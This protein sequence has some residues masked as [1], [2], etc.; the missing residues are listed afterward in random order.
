MDWIQIIAL[1]LIFIAFMLPSLRGSAKTAEAKKAP[2]DDKR[3][4]KQT[5]H[6]EKWRQKLEAQDE[7]DVRESEKVLSR[8]PVPKSPNLL[9]LQEKKPFSSK[10]SF[11]SSLEKR[12]L[13]SAIEER[14]LSSAISAKGGENLVSLP[15]S[16]EKI[17][18]KRNKISAAGKILKRT[19][20]RN[21]IISH[22]ILKRK[23]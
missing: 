19:S 18:K 21:L 20:K 4:Q 5:L 17:S 10:F 7:K 11:S 9:S 2:P 14:R 3:H 22:E 23:F 16:L 8:P 12:K 15:I 13:T 6:Q 1:I